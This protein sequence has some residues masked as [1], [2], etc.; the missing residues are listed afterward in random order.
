MKT[1][2]TYLAA[3]AMGLAFELVFKESVVFSTTMYFVADIVL[4]LGIFIVFPLSFFTMTAGTASLTREKGS[5]GYVWLSTIFWALFTTVVLA[6]TASALFRVYPAAF[7][8]TSTTI[9][10]AEEATAL[11]QQLSTSTLVRVDAANPITNN[12]FLN[13][14]KSSDCLIPIAFLALIMG[15][16]FRPTTEIVRPAYITL[17]SISEVMFRL[18]KKVAQLLWI[19]IFFLSGVWFDKLWND[20]TVFYSWQFII[21]CCFIGVAVLLL[22]IP[23][24]YAIATGFKRNPYRQIGRLLSAGTAGLFSENYLFAQP[25]LYTDCRI[26]LGIQKRVVSTALPIHSFITK[27]GTALIS[28]MCTCSLIYAINETLPTP[29]QT[30]TIALACTLA[31]FICCLHAGYEV[32][33]AT[34]FALSLLKVDIKGAEFSILGILPLLNGI[35]I[36][37]DVLLAGLGTSFTAYQ[38]KADCNIKERDI[39]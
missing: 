34:S 21:L 23:L 14:L 5:N 7:P 11:Y 25:A 15:Y 19:A 30:I 10:E 29:V 4:R 39:V 31:S 33:F 1:W 36:M 20:A 27:G 22:V 35:A 17:N 28:T 2:L 9:K 16:A 13:L 18:T 6:V 38:L 26:N 12:A 32:L 8:V 3:S 24:I 37:F